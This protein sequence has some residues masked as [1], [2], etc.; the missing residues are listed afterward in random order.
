[1]HTDMDAST[2]LDQDS[3][4]AQCDEYGGDSWVGLGSYSHG[5]YDNGPMNEYN[6]FA[7]FLPQGLSDSLNGM[8]P[9]STHLQPAPSQQ[10]HHHQNH[11]LQLIQ[12]APAPLSHGLPL[13]NTAWPSQLTNPTPTSSNS[14]FSAPPLPITPASSGP[15]AT[16]VRRG[17]LVSPTTPGQAPRA[18]QTVENAKQPGQLEKIPRKTLS[19]EQKRAMCQYHDENPGTR[20]ADIGA[21]FG[22]ERSTVSKVLRHRDQYLKR[23]QDADFA[24]KRAKGKH[25][26]FDRTLSNYVRRQQQSGFDVKDDEI[27]EQ[28]RL[29]ARASGNQEGLLGTLT[30]N[31]LQKF[32]QK[33]GI[34][35]GSGRLMRRASETNI[36]DS[37]RMSTALAALKR[38]MTPR[39]TTPSVMSPTSPTRP[40]S[41]L[42]GSRSDEDLHKD[43]LEFELTYRAQG[44][45][46]NT[47]SACET[48]DNTATILSPDDVS[49]AASFSFSPDS[50]VA[51]FSAN[52]PRQMSTGNPPGLLQ[53]DKRSK[54]FPTM[55]V[56][57]S[58][59]KAPTTEAS[60]EPK[61]PRHPPLLA[62]SPSSSM[63][64][65]ASE[66]RNGALSFNSSLASPPS[67][68]RSTSNSSLTQQTS[69][70]PS[71]S[72]FGNSFEPSVDCPTL[73]EAR[74]AASI[75]LSFIQRMSSSGQF[76]HI[77]YMTVAQLSQKLQPQHQLSTRR[78]IG[79]LSRI[80][81]GDH[82]FCGPAEISTGDG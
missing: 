26:D 30:G 36:P 79:G 66:I 57:F 13:L 72:I 5:P 31:W 50:T 71:N 78:S 8:P 16:P 11:H 40:L 37:A 34:G 80:P 62:A 49:P 4:M 24:F 38:A 14:S 25:P 68:H 73:E 42:S 56:N 82:E 22:V 9:P 65:P 27:L 58:R 60:A 28:A 12:P 59:Q 67:L 2:A 48:Q 43:T 3:A 35:V 7:Q 47:P 41:P 53:R 74:H 70:Q 76:D 17:S 55:D 63:Q 61:T 44:S 51:T 15:P 20:Q 77:D 46:S 18:S 52:R 19:T 29:F 39:A 6:G 75:L 21:K 23:E 1:M 69:G 10:L 81:E 54:T 32:K 45:E 33:H 64:S